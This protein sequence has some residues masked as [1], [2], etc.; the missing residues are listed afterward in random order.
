[1]VSAVL[2]QCLD[3]ANLCAERFFAQPHAFLCCACRMPVSAVKH[4]LRGRAIA[5]ALYRSTRKL[6]TLNTKLTSCMSVLDAEW[7]C[8]QW[9]TC[10][11]CS[12][13]CCL[14]PHFVRA[15]ERAEQSVSGNSFSLLMFQPSAYTCA[16]SCRP[17]RALS[18]TMGHTEEPFS[19]L[20]FCSLC[21]NHALV[22]CA[23][24]SHMPLVTGKL[25][26]A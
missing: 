1:M 13:S 24:S 5:C 18:T 19:C 11:G 26:R 15:H 20:C 4:T 21:S 17:L 23:S 25:A 3:T 12:C 6:S 10:T 7:N 2:G 16:G 8:L 9:L 22:P 14:C